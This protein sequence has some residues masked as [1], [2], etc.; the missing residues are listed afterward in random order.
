MRQRGVF[1]IQ[2][3]SNKNSTDKYIVISVFISRCLEEQEDIKLIV[4]LTK[5]AIRD[6]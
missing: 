4:L 2:F 1:E 3:K 5:M 6:L